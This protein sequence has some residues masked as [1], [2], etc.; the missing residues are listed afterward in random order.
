MST[1]KKKEVNIMPKIRINISVDEE[2]SGMLKE[3]AKA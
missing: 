3:L 2:V 1:I